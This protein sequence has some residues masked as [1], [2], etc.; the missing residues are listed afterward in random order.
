MQK[1]VWVCVGVG[2]W[3]CGWVCW[4]TGGHPCVFSRLQQQ[5]AKK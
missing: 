5:N 1:L 2:M 3:V 4:G